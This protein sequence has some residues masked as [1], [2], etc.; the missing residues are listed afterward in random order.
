MDPGL[1]HALAVYAGAILIGLALAYLPFR[2]FVRAQPA[3]AGGKLWAFAAVLGFT[4]LGAGAYAAIGKPS[5]ADAP[6]EARYAA[7]EADLQSRTTMDALMGVAPEVMLEV[8]AERARRNPGD[9]R[10]HF[11]AGQYRLMLSDQADAIIAQAD[12][13]GAEADVA[14]LNAQAKSWRDEAIGDFQRALRLAPRDPDVMLAIADTL[15]ARPGGPPPM[16]VA[17]LYTQAL[18]LMKPDDPRRAGAQAAL[19]RLAPPAEMKGP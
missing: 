10:P 16:V 18:A 13:M 2:A 11:F 5:L 6:Y 1:T 9:A 7:F 8:L 17:G 14:G 19:K 3:G 4:A 12:Q 15:S